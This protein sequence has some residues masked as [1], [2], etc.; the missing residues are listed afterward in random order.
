MVLETLLPLIIE[1]LTFFSIY[2]VC[3]SSLNLQQGYTGISNLG[4]FFSIS[5]GA[6][7]IAALPTR[8]AV[9]LYG[10]N[11]DFVYQNALVVS[12]LN[13]RFAKDALTPT[14]LLIITFFA[15]MAVGGI[16]G[17]A[18]TYL[19]LRL[20]ETY[21]AVFFLC[22]AEAIKIFGEN[23]I[24]LAGGPNGILLP[25]FFIW[26]GNY[27]WIFQSAFFI[28]IPFIIF[29]VYEKVTRSPFGRLLKAIRENELAVQCLGRNTVS[30][31]LKVMAF[32]SAFLAVAGVLVS[33][34]M[35]SVVAGTFDR[36]DYSFWPWLMVM[37][38]GVGNNLGCLLGTFLCIIIRRIVYWLKF[39]LVF[40]PVDIMWLEYI[41]LGLAFMI[42][43]I[44]KPEGI[45]PEKPYQVKQQ[46]DSRSN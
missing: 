14:L 21:L 6:Y 11:M 38:G 33:L 8:L 28:I 41:L 30:V 25:N 24:P 34:R 23:F 19:S 39:Y 31:K 10:I 46:G 37:L 13:E 12:L 27:S 43:M 36:V 3:S 20:T 42:V 4:L 5:S 2:L 1:T 44:Y 18:F 35:R 32:T 45:L 22:V 7:V 29:A 9:W 15:A 40:L 26:L 16:L 17:Y